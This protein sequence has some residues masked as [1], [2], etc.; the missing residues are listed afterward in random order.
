[1]FAVTNPRTTGRRTRQTRAAQRRIVKNFSAACWQL[2]AP[3]SLPLDAL[4]TTMHWD[5]R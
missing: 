1:M 5:S 3:E 4:L 2:V